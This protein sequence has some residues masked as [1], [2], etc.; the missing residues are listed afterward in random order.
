MINNTSTNE[1]HYYYSRSVVSFICATKRQSGY[2]HTPGIVQGGRVYKFKIGSPLESYCL[3]SLV[4]CT[5]RSV[6]CLAGR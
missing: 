4:A 6:L 3:I 2:Y 1:A 5:N